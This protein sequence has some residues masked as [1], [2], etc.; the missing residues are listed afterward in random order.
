MS[1]EFMIGLADLAEEIKPEHIDKCLKRFLE[2]SKKKTGTNIPDMFS[3]NPLMADIVMKVA[4]GVGLRPDAV[5]QIMG[6]GI[7]IGIHLVLAILED[8][9]QPEEAQNKL[10]LVN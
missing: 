7:E 6:P 5:I 3:E 1:E 9:E 4:I 10:K 2:A 8:Q